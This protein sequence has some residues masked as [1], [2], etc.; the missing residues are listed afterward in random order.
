MIIIHCLHIVNLGLGTHFAIELSTTLRPVFVSVI[1]DETT[2]VTVE[3]KL[4][5]MVEFYDV[6][7]GKTIVELLDLVQ[8]EDGKAQTLVDNLLE[9]F[10]KKTNS[11][12]QVKLLVHCSRQVT[13]YIL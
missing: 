12:G 10:E 11:T 1:I 5:V 9:L 2:D 3:K 7:K 13:N 6:V 4:A 8:C